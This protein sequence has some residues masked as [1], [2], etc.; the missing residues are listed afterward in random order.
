MEKHFEAMQYTKVFPFDVAVPL[1]LTS[2]AGKHNWAQAYIVWHLI[3]PTIHSF[4]TCSNPAP[5]LAPD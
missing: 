1:H 2:F 5:R 3:I 4:F